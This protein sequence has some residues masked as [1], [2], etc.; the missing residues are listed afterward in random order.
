MSKGF[1]VEFEV[2]KEQIDILLKE[3]KKLKKYKKS[4]LFTI[5]KLDGKDTI[6]DQ[7]TREA[8]EDPID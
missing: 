7:L 4:N 3:Y 6:I 2:P 1:D 8:E 5:E